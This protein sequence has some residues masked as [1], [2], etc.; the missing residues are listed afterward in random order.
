MPNSPQRKPSL[1]LSWAYAVELLA[2]GCLHLFI[3]LVMGS[4]PLAA[5]IQRS[6]KDWAT[7]E[8]VL[9]AAGLVI[10][11]IYFNFM[12]TEFGDYLRWDGSEP[13]F[14]GAFTYAVFIQLFSAVLMVVVANLPTVGSP[15]N[16]DGKWIWLIHFSFL[17]LLLAL[18]NVR[19]LFNNM[20]VLLQLRQEFIEEKRKVDR[21]A[22]KR[23]L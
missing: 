11:G 7:L 6:A 19:T 17:I 15:P 21:E 13:A 12:A 20:R 14:R 3:G 9:L 1:L 10:W 16:P 2:A 4:T 23:K 18:I 8:G 5:F 22:G